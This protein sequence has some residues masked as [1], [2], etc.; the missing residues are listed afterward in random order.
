MEKN[1]GKTYMKILRKLADLF[2]NFD[3][4]LKEEIEEEFSHPSI[5]Q[6]KIE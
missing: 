5:V 1:P 2:N 4:E 6:V 3:L